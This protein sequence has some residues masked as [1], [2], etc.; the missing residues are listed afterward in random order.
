M[1]YLLDTCVLSEAIKEKPFPAVMRW[2]DEVNEET[3]YISSLTVGEIVR[4]IFKLND[5][6]K[7]N[8]LINWLEVDLRNRFD[9]RILDITREISEQW[10]KIAATLEL[11]G[12]TAPVIDCLLAA[13]AY[14][15]GLILVTRNT[16]DFLNMPIELFN[17]WS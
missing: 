7:K 4:G 17:P 16:K 9:T 11:D 13:T 6:K 3:C 5:S 2:L 8:K 15:H 1:K 10:G 14:A 12:N